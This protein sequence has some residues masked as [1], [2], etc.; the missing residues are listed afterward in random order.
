[1]ILRRSSY[2]HVIAL[3]EGRAL[4]VHAVSQ[5]RLAVDGEVALLLACF[6]S[7]RLLPRDFAALSRRVGYDIETLARGVA[8]LLERGFLT[9]K[10]PEDEAAAV[11]RELNRT[12]AR[13]PAEQLDKYRRARGEGAL[14]Y[15]AA[16][17]T[18]G[19]DDLA[20]P[21]PRLDVALLG[22]C[23]L[24]MEAEFLAK[25]G[26]ER[27]LDLRVGASFP[28]D[29]RWV[30]ERAFDVILVGA[31][32]SRGMVA[33]GRIEDYIDEARRLLGELRARSAAPILI[34]N[35]PEPTLQ[36][37]GLAERGLGAHR[38]LFRRAN[39][40]L[41]ELCAD[42]T[43]VH[44]IDV[45]AHLGLE[46]SRGLVDDGLT[47]FTH[48]GSPGW[49]LQR[50][51]A[52]K[53]AT[54]GLFPDLEPLA[55][56][57]GRD[58]YRREAVMARAHLDA[59]V[60]V[61]GVDAKKCVIV[62]LDGV[63]WPGV[64]AET[65]APFAWTPEISGL[66][67][68]IGLYVGLHEALKQLKRRGVLLAAVSKN[69]EV[70]VRELWRYPEGYPLD[71]LL[72]PGDFVATRINWNDKA[73]N[74]REIAAELGFA[75]E[76]FVFIDDNP[77]ERERVRQECPGVEVWGEDPFALR[78]LLLTDPRLQRPRLTE[79]AA[80]RQASTRA[81]AAREAG[82]SRGADAAA[83]LA[84]LEIECRVERLAGAAETERVVELFQRVTQ[85]N[86]T[87][88]KFSAAE[89][90]QADVFIMRVRDRLADHGLV[91]A[92]VVIEGEIAGFAMSC[93]VIG[94]GVEHRL[95]AG[96]VEGMADKVPALVADYIETPRN[97][98]ARHLFRDG[99]FALGDDGAWRIQLGER[100]AA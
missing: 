26:R 1:M 21:R 48:L 59:I 83:F 41:A 3:G 84:S 68:Y 45:A 9:D 90:A 28:D 43:D 61:L 24:Q 37:G 34:D 80:L 74:I 81:R 29:P 96:V 11:V 25:E 94:L 20:T 69:D 98:P 66:A 35:L 16:P 79:E 57:L 32:R 53:A 8:A 71:R 50:P 10:A 65:G 38:N 47:S 5:M 60:G 87:G 4:F 12:G 64:L 27:G 13:D 70:V 7:P 93:R 54:H 39:L 89:L 100:R 76:A 31:L 63:L 19:L 30:E 36:P 40:A 82:L 97:A 91:G 55:K 17:P 62:D 72:T 85:F 95:L 15:W 92:A 6:D 49:M 14:D 18:R 2:A 67:S 75:P 42:L 73:S 88:R 56:A 44:V 86:T 51:E 46:G 33:L 52:E 22:D 99:G 23:D 58:P 78:W 77:L